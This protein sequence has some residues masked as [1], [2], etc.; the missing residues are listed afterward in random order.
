MTDAAQQILERA[1]TLSPDEREELLAALIRGLDGPPPSADEQAR[2]DAA[3]AVEIR[4]RVAAYRGGTANL[5][6]A[7][8]VYASLRAGT[9]R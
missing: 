5:I 7:A 2:I 6:D 9:R 3:W 8:E 4:R 1:L